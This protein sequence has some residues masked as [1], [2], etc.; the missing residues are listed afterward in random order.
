[1]GDQHDKHSGRE[2]EV[3]EPLRA[4]ARPCARVVSISLPPLEKEKS[5]KAV[6]IEVLL[7]WA[8]GREKVRLAREPSFGESAMFRPRAF[9]GVDSSQRIGAA[10]GSSMNLGFMA[11]A[12]AYA[13]RDA[14]EACGAANLVRAYA[15]TGRRPDWI[16]QPKMHTRP[17]AY[18]AVADPDL[19]GRNGRPIVI[20]GW[21]FFW[22]GDLPEIVEERRQTY[23]RW[24]QG[25]ARVHAELQHRLVAHALKPDL[26]PAERWLESQKP[27]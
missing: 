14:V 26:P 25:I 3:S 6:T 12:D 11:P 13:V 1:M 18:F 27:L 7:E 8:Y 23:R 19:K 10:V 20:E 24:A 9:G 17:G 22:C 5:R 21:T 4:Q 15:M 2:R 16:P